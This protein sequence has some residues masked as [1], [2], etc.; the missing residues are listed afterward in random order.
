VDAIA[1]DPATHPYYLTTLSISLTIPNLY[2]PP[3]WSFLA[4]A[5]DH[6]SSLPWLPIPGLAIAAA[7][8]A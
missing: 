8:A 7:P 3:L 5:R 2:L 6:A 4:A 1:S